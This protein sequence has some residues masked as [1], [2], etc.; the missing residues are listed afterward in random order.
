MP[1]WNGLSGVWSTAVDYYLGTWWLTETLNK[2]YTLDVSNVNIMCGTPGEM[3]H[4]IGKFDSRYSM[5]GPMLFGTEY[6]SNYYDFPFGAP[7]DPNPGTLGFGVPFWSWWVPADVYAYAIILAMYMN[8]NYVIQ[9]LDFNVSDTDGAKTSIDWWLDPPALWIEPGGPGYMVPLS[10][11]ATGYALTWPLRV[12]QWYDFVIKYGSVGSY[13][14]VPTRSLRV[15]VDISTEDYF[16][17]GGADIWRNVLLYGSPYPTNNVTEDALMHMPIKMLNKISVGIDYEA[18]VLAHE[19]SV[20]FGKVQDAFGYQYGTSLQAH[21]AG[22]MDLPSVGV[23]DAATQSV[24]L[25]S[26]LFMSVFGTYIKNV[27]VTYK[28]GLCTAKISGQ[29]PLFW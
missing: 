13:F 8:T 26:M 2:N 21:N 5:T 27:S 25:L 14:Y 1:V 7:R 23:Y 20:T 16:P 10:S 19:D 4:N 3:V 6:S 17:L 12:G 15:G 28:P 9:K 22:I 18:I 29:M 24:E 11:W